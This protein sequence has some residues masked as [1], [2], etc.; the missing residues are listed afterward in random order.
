MN[1]L[2]NFATSNRN[3]FEPQLQVPRQRMC[4]AAALVMAYRKM[5]VYVDQRDVWNNIATEHH[6]N[7]RAHTFRMAQDAIK[8]GL[9]ALIIQSHQPWNILKT[10]WRNNV[11]AIVNHRVD[12]NSSEGHYS[13]LAGIGYETIKLSDPLLGPEIEREQS[14][15]LDSW[16]PRG[17]QCEI[18]GNV[19]LAIA[20]PSEQP[21]VWSHC[22]RPFD[23]AVLCCR[24]DLPI[25]LKPAMALGC[26]NPTCT[27]RL[28]CR[29][30]CPQCDFPITEL[31]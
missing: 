28:W 21:S 24:C 10:C 18:A 9:D 20:N 7:F 15:F 26:W 2:A 13:M 11:S 31:D 17:D 23:D 25:S 12:T 8:R 4:G 30:F 1:I 29:I 6:G 5:G 3:N 14:S 19:L 27:Q 16:L 22:N